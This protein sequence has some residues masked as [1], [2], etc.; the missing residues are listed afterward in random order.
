MQSLI[1]QELSLNKALRWCGVTRKRRYYVLRAR[2]SVVDP[3]MLRMIQDIREE[4]P[5]YGTRRTAAELSRRLNRTVNRKL[6]RRIYKRMGWG[7]VL[8]ANLC[9]A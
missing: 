2:E 3:D 1:R 6:V 7:R 5:F 4:R 9:C 8:L